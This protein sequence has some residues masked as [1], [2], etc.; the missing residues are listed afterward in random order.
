ML[1]LF[2][3]A[4]RSG[5]GIITAA[6]EMARWT[7]ERVAAEERNPSEL[8]SASAR[9]PARYFWGGARRLAAATSDALA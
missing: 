7:S 8:K 3:G 6:G 5:D 2:L 9:S 4:D 1:C